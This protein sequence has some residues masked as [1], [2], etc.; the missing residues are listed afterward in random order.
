MFYTV[1]VCHH[2]ACD[3]HFLNV[4]FTP[5]KLQSRSPLLWSHPLSKELN[6][7][8]HSSIRNAGPM[9]LERF[10][11]PLCIYVYIDLQVVGLTL[12]WK[13]IGLFQISFETFSRKTM[14]SSWRQLGE[15]A[16]NT[17]FPWWYPPWRAYN[18]CFTVVAPGPCS[19]GLFILQTGAWIHRPLFSLMT[20]MAQE[21][22]GQD[23]WQGA[24]RE[25]SIPYLW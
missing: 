18:S 2:Y 22:K 4:S 24:T 13:K 20:L 14:K 16:F 25:A 19:P 17:I 10:G 5:L 3:Q 1:K 23:A 7:Y 12:H 9:G 21:K 15:M 8:L 11:S 6:P